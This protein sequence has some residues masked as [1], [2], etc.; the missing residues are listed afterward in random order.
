MSS[1]KITSNLNEVINII[2]DRLE[3][4]DI[5][6]MT[7]LQASTVLGAIRKRIHVEGKDSAGTQIGIYSP[8]YMKVRTGLYGNAKPK[9]TGK[10]VNSAGTHLKGKSKGSQRPKFQRKADTKVI[11]SLT[12]QMENDYTIIPIENGT[13]IGFNTDLS[14]RKSQWNE[15]TYKK[16]I[17]SLTKE[18]KEIIQKTGETF[19]NENL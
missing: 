8:G 2:S 10:G 11:L 18:E 15:A 9:K 16:K 14:F 7:A 19:I 13:A 1:L 5:E 6:K 17:F 4:I 12:S 3:G